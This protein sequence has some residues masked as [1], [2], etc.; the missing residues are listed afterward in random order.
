M[1]GWVDMP[2][3]EACSLCGVQAFMM[4]IVDAPEAA[5]RLLAHLTKIVIDFALAQVEEPAQT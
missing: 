1:L 5:H 3:A 4:M 2:F